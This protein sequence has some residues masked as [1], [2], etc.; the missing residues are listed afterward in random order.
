LAGIMLLILSPLFAVIS[1]LIWSSDRG[2]AFFTQYRIGR[3]GKKF[4]V[5]KFRTMYEDAEE[6]LAPLTAQNES[7]GML[8][9]I[10]DDPR[11]TPVGRFLRR[12]SLDE[13]PQ[14]LNVIRGEMSLVGPRP[15]PADD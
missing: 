4:R 3:E 5:M 13:L 6:R 9:K 10:R 11:I 2:P 1:M 14:L 7:N 8:F 15:L 12:T